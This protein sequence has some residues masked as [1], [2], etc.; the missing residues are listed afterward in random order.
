MG[1]KFK[2]TMRDTNK[3]VFCLHPI[4]CNLQFFNVSVIPG[5]S[6]IPW[7]EAA[8]AIEKEILNSTPEQKSGQDSSSNGTMQISQT[9][10]AR[11]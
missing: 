2:R 9:L 3:A 4:N 8:K 7:D 10:W 11:P 6:R 5:W 1:I